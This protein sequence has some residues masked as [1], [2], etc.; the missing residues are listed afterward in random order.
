MRGAKSDR[1]KGIVLDSDKVSAEKKTLYLSKAADS[2]FKEIEHLG[3]DH[4][5][6][7]HSKIISKSIQT[8]VENKPDIQLCHQYDVTL[9]Q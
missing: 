8:L 1:G 7:E 3:F 9:K 2:M 5:A 6:L 4:Q